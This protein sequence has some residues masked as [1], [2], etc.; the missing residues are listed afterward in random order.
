MTLD[1]LLWDLAVLT[2]WRHTVT[3][4]AGQLGDI[5]EGCKCTPE[6][7]LVGAVKGESFQKGECKLVAGQGDGQGAFL[8]VMQLG[9]LFELC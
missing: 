1:D 6:A 8:A 2:C 7:F 3:Q 4:M 9:M 5:K